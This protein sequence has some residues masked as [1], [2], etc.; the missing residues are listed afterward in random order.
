MNDLA[1]FETFQTIPSMPFIVSRPKK[2]KSS[3]LT[4]EAREAISAGII[5]NLEP[6]CSELMRIFFME[7][8][9]INATRF[10]PVLQRLDFRDPQTFSRFEKGGVKSYVLVLNKYLKVVLIRWEPGHYGSVHGHASGGCV[11]K[12]L[13]GQLEERRYAP[14]IDGE[15]VSVSQYRTGSMTYLDDHMAYHAVGNVSRGSAYSLHV[16]TPGKG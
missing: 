2:S 5:P 7:T 1:I 11:F 16:Y 13:Q 12:V 8:G 14:V 10:L 15:L 9:T 3:I 6:V 4:D